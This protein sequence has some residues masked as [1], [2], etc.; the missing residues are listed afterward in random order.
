MSKIN[1]DVNCSKVSQIICQIIIDLKPMDKGKI[2][3]FTHE[4]V[5][6]RKIFMYKMKIE[7]KLNHSHILLRVEKA[8]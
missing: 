2:D 6:V 3:E 5:D 7:R 4:Q 1:L 8:K